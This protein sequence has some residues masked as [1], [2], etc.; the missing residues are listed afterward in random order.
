MTVRPLDVF[1]LSLCA[2]SLALQLDLG[3]IRAP[4]NNCR[5]PP[6]RPGIQRWVF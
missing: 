5:P 2:L 3:S 6:A 1:T 4:R